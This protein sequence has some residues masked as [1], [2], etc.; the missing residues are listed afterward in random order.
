M[1]HLQKFYKTETSVPVSDILCEKLV[2]LL[3]FQIK[4][5]ESFKVTS[6]SFLFHILIYQI[7]N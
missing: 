2:S 4:F 6:V 5:D 3:K 1:N 7:A